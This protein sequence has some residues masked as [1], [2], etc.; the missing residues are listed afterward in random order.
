[1]RKGV[2]VLFENWRIMVVGAGTM[3]HSI[4]LA[5]AVH[6]FETTLVDQ[7]PEQ[8]EK[9]QKMI[10]GNLQTLC[11][12]GEIPEDVV[13]KAQ[14]LITYTDKLEE[15]APQANF[16]VETIYESPPAK[17][18]LFAILDKLCS[19]DTIF[20]SNTSALNIF[21]IAEVSHPERLIIAHWFNPPHI[22]PLVEVVRGLQTSDETVETVKALL[23]KLGKTP[24]VLNQYVP[25]FIVNRFSA[26]I[27]REAGY[28]MA[29]G[30]CTW[31][32]IDTAVVSTY[33]PRFAFEG[34]LE[35]RDHLGWDISTKVASFLF[36]HLCN[37]TGP[38]PLAVE[39]V[40]KG[41]LGV[42]SG[43]GLKDYSNVDI[44]E[45]Q[46]ERTMKIFKMLKNIR[47]L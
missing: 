14:K 24:A 27:A 5:F 21:E 20:T 11:S 15:G 10:A 38:M 29:Q 41:W 31:E 33:G 12:V 43:R 1:M 46:K 13:E 6:G 36:P 35:L 16:V 3:G 30:W 45:I 39:M 8:L 44:Q 32:D 9:A 37:D 42:K 34:P 17:R 22:M 40:Q 26:V 23:T 47:E 18:E 25:G 7:S 19:A 4:A 2:N 28:M